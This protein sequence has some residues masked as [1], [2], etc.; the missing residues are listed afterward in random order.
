METTKTPCCAICLSAF[1][2]ENR[3]WHEC[4]VHP[5]VVIQA[6]PL[7]RAAFPLVKS[8]DWCGEFKRTY[9]VVGP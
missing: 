9:E 6:R 3:N 8:A 2:T 1:H 4:R 5:P 7:A